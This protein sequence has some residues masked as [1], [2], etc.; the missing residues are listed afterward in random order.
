MGKRGYIFNLI[1][2]FKNFIKIYRTFHISQK[3]SFGRITIYIFVSILSSFKSHQCC[4]QNFP[5]TTKRFMFDLKMNFWLLN[6][7]FK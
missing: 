3:M 7:Q 1:F 4:N 6:N 2:F 5:N